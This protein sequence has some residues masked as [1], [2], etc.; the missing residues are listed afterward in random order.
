MAGMTVLASMFGRRLLASM[1]AWGGMGGALCRGGAAGRA[2]CV[3]HVAGMPAQLAHL[4][5]GRAPYR[6]RRLLVLRHGLIAGKSRFVAQ[7]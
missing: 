1:L 3:F 2:S 5:V 4:V 6:M 7:D